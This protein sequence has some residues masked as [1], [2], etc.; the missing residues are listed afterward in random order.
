MKAEPMVFYVKHRTAQETSTSGFR[1]PD[2]PWAYD[3]PFDTYSAAKKHWD[4]IQP[5]WQEGHVVTK[6]PHCDQYA[7]Y[8]I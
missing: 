1:P 5:N 7:R 2:Y 4:E 6:C 3:G 8:P